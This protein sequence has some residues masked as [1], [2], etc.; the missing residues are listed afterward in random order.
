MYGHSEINWMSCTPMSRASGRTRTRVVSVSRRLGL[1]APSD[2][3]LSLSSFGTPVH[4][5]WDTVSTQKRHGEGVCVNVNQAWSRTATVIGSS[6]SADVELPAL[7][8]RPKYLPHKFC[9]LTL[10]LV[11]IPPSGN[12][13]RASE[14]VP[15][16]SRSPLPTPQ[17]LSLGTLMAAD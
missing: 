17:R 11:Y 6:T 13:T 14:T 15:T 9:Q 7:T 5:D 8:F 1:T 16:G 2:L 4:L 3:Q 10:V 12:M